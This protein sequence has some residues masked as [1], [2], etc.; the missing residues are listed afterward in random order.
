MA[1]LTQ[2]P[3]SVIAS[4]P[5]P[6]YID[7]VTR[8]AGLVVVNVIFLVLITVC[9]ALRLYTRI[10][11]KRWFGIDDWFIIL[12]YIF[13]VGTDITV[14]LANE[15]YYWNRHIWDIPLNHAS[16]VLKI[17]LSATIL[18][19]AASSCTRI[20]LLCFY[21]RLVREAKRPL[22]R[23]VLHGSLVYIV[24]IWIT[25]TFTSLFQCQ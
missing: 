2:I 18:F 14:I 24:A 11:I 3:L 10:A 17:V 21:Y 19:T 23:W 4:F 13:T 12:A 8:G 16:G 1:A 6:N 22:F 15:R 5:T 9:V 20:S 25:F 7:P